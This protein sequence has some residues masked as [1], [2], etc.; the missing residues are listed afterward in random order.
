MQKPFSIFIFCLLLLTGYRSFSQNILGKTELDYSSKTPE[1]KQMQKF[2]DVPVSYFNGTPQISIPV[3]TVTSKSI[4]V[5]LSI[6]YHGG[7]I[8]AEDDERYVGLGWA[9][10]GAGSITRT[11]RGNE[12]EGIQY[13]ARPY[14]YFADNQILYRWASMRDSM[15]AKGNV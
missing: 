8:K 4:S 13:E 10:K 9:F 1:V 11:V 12:D 14:K 5:P 7:G 2:I 3:H 15:A 6:V